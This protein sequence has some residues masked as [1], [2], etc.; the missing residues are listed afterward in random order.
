VTRAFTGRPARALAG[1]LPLA[2]PDAP[3]AY[4]EVHHLTRPLRAAAAA[5]GEPDLV[6]LWAGEGWRHATEEP[7]AALVARIAREAGLPDP[8][9]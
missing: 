2:H 3:A 8:A 9:A 7:A 1:P 4:P 6:H 5:A